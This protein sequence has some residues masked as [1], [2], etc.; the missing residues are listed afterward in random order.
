VESIVE[1]LEDLTTACI[2]S[3]SHST[4][5][6]MFLN[7]KVHEEI[8]NIIRRPLELSSEDSVFE[9]NRIIIKCYAFLREFCSNSKTNQAIMFSHIEFMINQLILYKNTEDVPE[10]IMQTIIAVFK[11]NHGLCRRVTERIVLPFINI[12]F[13]TKRHSTYVYMD[14]F[15]TII[16]PGGVIYKPN[17]NIVLKLLVSRKDAKD[18]IQAIKTDISSAPVVSAPLVPSFERKD[19]PTLMKGDGVVPTL[20]ISGITVDSSTETGRKKSARGEDKDKDK[21]RKTPKKKTKGKE[22]DDDG[23]KEKLSVPKSDQVEKRKSLPP[24]IVKDLTPEQIREENRAGVISL[25]AL[26]AEERNYFTE[27][28]CQKLLGIDECIAICHRAAYSENKP[29]NAYKIIEAFLHFIDEVYLN[30]E[31]SVQMMASSIVLLPN[32]H[33]LWDL[34]KQFTIDIRQLTANPKSNPSYEAYLFLVICP[35]LQHFFAKFS[36]IKANQLHKAISNELLDNLANLRK[37]YSEERNENFALISTMKILV[38]AGIQGSQG[39]TSVSSLPRATRPQASVHAEAVV[40]LDVNSMSVEAQF[41]EQMNSKVLEQ[42][43]K[44]VHI[45]EEARAAAEGKSAALEYKDTTVDAEVTS[46]AKG[47]GLHRRKSEKGKGKKGSKTAIAHATFTSK[48]IEQSLRNLDY[49]TYVEL[50]VTQIRNAN[51]TQDFKLT[52]T[53]LRLVR[54][55]VLSAND[56]DDRRVI[57][58]RFAELDTPLSVIKLLRSPHPKVVAAASSA[59]RSLLDEG[60]GTNLVKPSKKTLDNI[61]QAFSSGGHQQFF[62]DILSLVQQSKTYLKEMKRRMQTL[63]PRRRGT[64]AEKSLPLTKKSSKN[65]TANG[66]FADEMVEMTI[67]NEDDGR[68]STASS[69]QL[70]D[71]GRI[72]RDVYGS[73]FLL[74]QG[75]PIFK[76]LVQ[77]IVRETVLYLK[78]YE[79]IINPLNIDLAIQVF[80]TLKE[81]CKEALQNQQVVLASQVLI[82]VNRLLSHSF[83]TIGDAIKAS[84]KG[85]TIA[86]PSSQGDLADPDFYEKSYELKIAIVDFLFVMLEA[87]DPSIVNEIVSGLNFAACVRV[88]F[89]VANHMNK[90]LTI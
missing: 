36:L 69:Q 19:T 44:L 27:V 40:V 3:S 82:P 42:I 73:L 72:V 61:S 86:T 37:C 31:S 22:K 32:N 48:L 62:E 12:I 33:L 21:R 83:L 35:F 20:S 16:K 64:I 59:L 17:Q 8:I 43:V 81:V 80:V 24:Q 15:K 26:C 41:F 45:E 53:C 46:E 54:Q 74:A 50:I 6:K 7:M 63:A 2:D 89:D 51:V 78:V 68:G 79:S 4:F 88:F 28:T 56:P 75:Y 76:S 52:R 11:D 57:Q 71:P 84:K 18:L 14:F 1:I 30:T 10:A 39:T 47:K 38:E 70:I 58:D 13:E 5:Q 67:M 49:Q 60:Y 77:D 55:F 34:I 66:E 25:L 23:G 87:S 65:L 29:A 90:P 9:I 85:V